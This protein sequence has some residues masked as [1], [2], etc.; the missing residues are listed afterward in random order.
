MH[1]EGARIEVSA[2]LRMETSDR[3][4]TVGKG[5]FE[6]LS[7]GVFAVAITL[8]ILEVRLPSNVGRSSPLQ[9]Q[10]HALLAIW[11]QYLV[12]AATFATI[13]VMWLNHHAL[14]DRAQRITHGVIMAN[15]CLLC[16]IC[17]L[18]FSTYT[19]EVFG[20]SSAAIT[21]YGL[22]HIAIGYSFL[23]VQRAVL[24]AHGRRAAPFTPWNVVGLVAYPVATVAGYFWPLLGLIIIVL[25]AIF[26]TL[27]G[28]IEYS[29]QA[30]A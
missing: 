19:F 28:N 11:P 30:L 9:A 17:F 21:F 2:V 5:R 15:L 13:G 1:R 16:A 10:I 12:Y 4:L 18:P 6:A 14:L 22:T 3:E 27:P 25:V 24:K 23:F 26:Y 8:L 29:R 20:L 7:D